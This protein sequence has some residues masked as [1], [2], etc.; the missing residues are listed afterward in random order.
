[1]AS[2]KSLQGLKYKWEPQP[3]VEGDPMPGTN[4]SRGSRVND[5]TVL[6]I[7]DNGQYVGVIFDFYSLVTEYTLD[8]FAQRFG[9]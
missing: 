9:S 6:G 8:Q 3:V 4:L 7:S 1:M 5:G 2:R